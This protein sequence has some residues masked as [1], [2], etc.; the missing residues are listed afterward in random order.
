MLAVLLLHHNSEIERT[1]EDGNERAQ[2]VQ[3]DWNTCKEVNN[4]GYPMPS[5][6]CHPFMTRRGQGQVSP[7]FWDFEIIWSNKRSIFLRD[8]GFSYSDQ[9]EEGI[10][11]SGF[12]GFKRERT[13][14]RMKFSIQYQCQP[15]Q[16]EK[17][18]LCFQFFVFFFNLMWN[19]SW[20]KWEGNLGI[21]CVLQTSKFLVN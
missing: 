20:R 15:G 12:F 14:Q 17:C 16:R 8:L 13:R 4:D 5:D 7:Y 11:V 1:G 19:M 6:L 2:K 18:R 9:H 21:K 3:C 10:R